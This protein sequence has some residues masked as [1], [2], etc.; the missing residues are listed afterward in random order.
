MRQR[1]LSG[2]GGRDLCDT[3]HDNLSQ[4]EATLRVVDDLLGASKV[5]P[6]EGR[7][8]LATPDTLRLVSP[9][10]R[11]RRY[12]FNSTRPQVSAAVHQPYGTW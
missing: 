4:P 7:W 3:L 10:S 2:L 5:E 12:P 1:S 11:R 9:R 8:E 6:E